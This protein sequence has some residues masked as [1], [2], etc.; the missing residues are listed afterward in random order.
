MSFELNLPSRICSLE[1]LPVMI[2]S[3]GYRQREQDSLT[4]WIRSLVSVSM[5]V[6]LVS[7]L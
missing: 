7:Q 4:G 6:A 3:H 1:L 5:H 2:A